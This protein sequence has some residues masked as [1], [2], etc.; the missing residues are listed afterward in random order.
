MFRELSPIVGA[1]FPAPPPT[2]R[3]YPAEKLAETLESP[4]DQVATSIKSAISLAGQ[5]NLPVLVTGSFFLAGKALEALL[6]NI[7]SFEPSSQ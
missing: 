1:M 2:E 6:P 4:I 7:H 5:T 3:G